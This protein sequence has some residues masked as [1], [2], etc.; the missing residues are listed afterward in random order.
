MLDFYFSLFAYSRQQPA[1]P[2]IVCLHGSL[3][4]SQ[5]LGFL[6]SLVTTEPLRVP[7]VPSFFQLSP[8]PQFQPTKDIPAPQALGP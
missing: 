1:R 4:D 6:G 3:E 5:P 2:P 7:E 8:T